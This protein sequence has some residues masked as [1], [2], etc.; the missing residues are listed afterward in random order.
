MALLTVCLALSFA[1]SSFPMPL[2]ASLCR[3][4]MKVGEQARG[5]FEP[6]H[7]LVALG[8]VGGCPQSVQAENVRI[9]LIDL[10]RAL[11]VL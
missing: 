8:G 7:E 2:S 4:T 9:N 1:F 3:Q 5:V 10:L 6:G 11:L